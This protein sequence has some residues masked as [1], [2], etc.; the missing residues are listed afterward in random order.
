MPKIW[1]VSW[2]DVNG[3]IPPALRL[4]VKGDSMNHLLIVEDQPDIRKLISMT[5]EFSDFEVHEAEDGT[6]GLQLVERI[7]PVV[8]LLDIMMPGELDGIQVC[9][10]I[11]Q[12]PHT[13]HTKVVLLTAR[14]QKTDLEAGK[15][16]GC[17]AYLVKPFSPLQLIDTIEQLLPG[18]DDLR[19]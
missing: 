15:R 19:N 5:L 10:R 6:T 8:V 11:K 13:S 7:R 1:H 3:K 18:P 4:P 9:E 17:D 12:N 2:L 14:G 16:A